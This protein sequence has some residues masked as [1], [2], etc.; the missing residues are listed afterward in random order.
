MEE[1]LSL[2]T[3]Y[4]HK[5]FKKQLSKTQ[6]LTRGAGGISQRIQ[7]FF[8]GGGRNKKGDVL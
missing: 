7:D 2:V 8:F 3:T 6:E 4:V 1:K 5:T